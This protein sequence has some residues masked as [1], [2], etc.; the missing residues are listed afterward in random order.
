M[1][2]RNYTTIQLSG[3]PVWTTA[4]YTAPAP[5]DITF[6]DVTTAWPRIAVEETTTAADSGYYR[7]INGAT[8]DAMCTWIERSKMAKKSNPEPDKEE[9]LQLLK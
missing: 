6:P 3:T 4:S 5:Y 8:W 7:W 1:P 9:L 2:V